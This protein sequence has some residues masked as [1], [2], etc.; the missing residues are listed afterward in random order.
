LSTFADRKRPMCRE[1]ILE[2]LPDNQD[3]GLSVEEIAEALNMPPS[4]VRN[5]LYR[6]RRQN[7]V[8]AARYT[9]KGKQGRLSKWWKV[10]GPV[11]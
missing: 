6:L 10:D 8:L 5:Q 3:E 1:Q 4:T 7:L 2:I 11:P 9:K